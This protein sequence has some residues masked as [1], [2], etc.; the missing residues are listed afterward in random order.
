M[1]G[2]FGELAMPVIM[3]KLSATSINVKVFIAF[4]RID[5]E[6]DCMDLLSGC[7]MM[8]GSKCITPYALQIWNTLKSEALV[9]YYIINDKRCL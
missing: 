5:S 8:Y 1:C 3:E 2:V 7:M 6:K 9:Y 4:I